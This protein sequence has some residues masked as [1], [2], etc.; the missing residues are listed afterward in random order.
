MCCHLSHIKPHR[1]S[2]APAPC[3]AM[4][5]P[6]HMMPPVRSQDEFVNAH[7]LMKARMTS[8]VGRAF[9]DDAT[10]ETVLRACMGS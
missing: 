2:I 4:S 7:P 10:R 3:H 9:P 6:D 8:Q 5:G 1:P